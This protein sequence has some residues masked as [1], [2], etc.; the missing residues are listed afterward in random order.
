MPNKKQHTDME[1]PWYIV[2]TRFNALSSKKQYRNGGSSK[3]IEK[4]SYLNPS[5]SHIAA[6]SSLRSHIAASS[7]STLS[8][9]RLPLF[10]S[11]KVKPSFTTRSLGSVTSSLR[12]ATRDELVVCEA[13][14]T[15]VEGQNQSYEFYFFVWFA[16]TC[17]VIY[18]YVLNVAIRVEVVYLH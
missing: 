15:V 5:V 11:L 7:V 8:P 2:Y 10:R 9:H 16:Q 14:D 6:S 4:A 13:Q 17:R 3:E 12:L 18:W 1:D